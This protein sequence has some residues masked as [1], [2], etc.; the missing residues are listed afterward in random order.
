MKLK[1]ICVAAA[2]AALCLSQTACATGDLAAVIKASDDNP[3]CYK[4]V[5]ATVTP[6]MLFGWAV[7]LIGGT[8]DKV[9]HADKAPKA[10]P[11]A[12]GTVVG[13]ASPSTP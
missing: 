3:E 10:A 4:N 7:P 12:V 5:H 2:A 6:V 11:I 13:S 1:M 8:Y 9:C